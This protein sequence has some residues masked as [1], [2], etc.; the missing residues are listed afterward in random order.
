MRVLAV[1]LFSFNSAESIRRATTPIL[2]TSFFHG[3]LV[4]V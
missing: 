2:L 3:I 4:R 1:L